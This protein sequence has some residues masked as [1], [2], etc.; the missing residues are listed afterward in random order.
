MEIAGTYHCATVDDTAEVA[1]KLAGVL[2]GGETILLN[3]EM[4][5]GKTT[6]AKAL[7]GALGVKRTVQSPT[8]AIVKEYKGSKLDIYHLDMYRITEAEAEELGIEEYFY[9]T[10]I[11]IIEWCKIK[12]QGRV[13]TVD[14]VATA[15]ERIVK[16]NK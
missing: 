14:I 4:G 16:I 8:F 5:A 1:K 15:T 7:I 6:F 10:S 13:I 3:G 11:V 12:P 2:A 9:D